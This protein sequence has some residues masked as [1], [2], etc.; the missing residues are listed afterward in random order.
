M[1]LQM[2]DAVR[3]VADA[4]THDIDVMKDSTLCDVLSMITA[5]L[6]PRGDVKRQLILVEIL[7]DVNAMRSDDDSSK[8]ND[9]EKANDDAAKK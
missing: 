3:S 1:S 7:R 2:P 5:K 4:Y 6:D 9:S 8:N